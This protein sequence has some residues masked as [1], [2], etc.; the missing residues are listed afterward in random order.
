MSI[1]AN[2]IYSSL[3]ININSTFLFALA[4][5][6][7]VSCPLKRILQINVTSNYSPVTKI[8][9]TNINKSTDADFG[10]SDTCCALKKKTL[11]DKSTLT[12][13][14]QRVIP[15]YFSDV[16]NATGFNINHYLSR[17]HRQPAY[18]ISSPHSSLP[19]YLQ[20]LR[21]RI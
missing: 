9:Q 20:H 14:V 21:L 12:Q 8:S 11:F 19:S 10:A 6:L 1:S 15:F 4:V 13:K 18:V 17:M 2:R 16:T 3:K 7:V 5:L